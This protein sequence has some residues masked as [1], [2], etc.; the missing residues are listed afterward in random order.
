MVNKIS[1]VEAALKRLAEHAR[2]CRLCPRECGVD[3][4][5]GVL[6]Y[7]EEGPSL[8][9]SHSLLHFGEE[10]VLSGPG[11]S[12]ANSAEKGRQRQGSGTIFI[13]GC[14]LR[15]AFCQNYQ[16][17]QLE[18]GEEQTPADLAR[19]MLDLEDQGAA[20]INL[21]SPTHMLLPILEALHTALNE[22]LTL[23]VVY[24][25]SGYESVQVLRCLEGIVD[26]Y[27]PDLKYASPA[28]SGSLSGAPDYFDKT[29]A[30]LTEMYCQQPVLETDSIGLARHG[31]IVRHLIL[32]GHVEDSCQVLDWLG[33]HLSLSVGLSLMSQYLP[34]F[35]APP[36][37]QRTLQADE[38]RRVQS[39]A[40]RLGFE[41]LFVQ[42]ESFEQ[43]EHLNP[44]FTRDN[45]F[46]WRGLK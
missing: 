3:R 6:G 21:V 38:Y 23:P 18:A 20:N 43:G 40:E 33:H 25:C 9:V 46:D 12:S 27:L 7:C 37:L 32:P 24:N 4:A 1:L 19:S 41:S 15:C 29:R 26:I 28:L 17:S 22:G 13:S 5:G 35:N 34:C 42:P 39:H 8:R 36:D 30:A 11:R 14:H 44:D 16:I 45:P 31:M 2:D 10:P